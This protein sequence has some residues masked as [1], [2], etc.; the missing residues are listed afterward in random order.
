MLSDVILLQRGLLGNNFLLVYLNFKRIR[1]EFLLPKIIYELHVLILVFLIKIFFYYQLIF[2]HF[3]Q[4][5]FFE[6]VKDNFPIGR[7]VGI[8]WFDLGKHLTL[9][10]LMVLPIHSHWTSATPV[11]PITGQCHSTS[12]RSLWSAGVCNWG[13]SQNH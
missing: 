10:L 4:N 13:S 6:K 12:F 5:L 1:I 2:V 3:I 8:Q 9:H 7:D 11:F